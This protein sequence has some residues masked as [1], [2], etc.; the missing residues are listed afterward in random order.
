VE[1]NF[2]VGL[3]PSV[4]RMPC[5]WSGGYHLL[6]CRLCISLDTDFHA[7]GVAAWYPNV[8]RCLFGAA[9]CLDCR[10][11]LHV[12]FRYVLVLE[13]ARVVA[14]QAGTEL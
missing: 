1:E 6:G 13:S 9:G 12:Y 4:S 8:I 14:E 2:N 5:F 3:G 10:D 11:N 7:G